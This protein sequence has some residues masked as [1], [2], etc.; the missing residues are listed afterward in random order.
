MAQN[1]DSHSIIV[2]KTNNSEKKSRRSQEFLSTLE[3]AST[4]LLNP[5]SKNKRTS[6]HKETILISFDEE[7]NIEQL[8]AELKASGLFDIVEPNFIGHGES[9]I[10]NDP[11]FS[12]RQ[13]YHVNNGSFNDVNGH[14]AKV[15]ADMDTDLAWDITTGSDQVVL[16]VFDSGLRLDHKEFEGR[17]WVNKGEIP[18]NG[19]DD[20]NNGYVDDINGWDFVNNDNDPTDD[21]AHG[22]N[23]TGIAASTGN[24]GFGMAGMDWNCKIMTLKVLDA[25]NSGRYSDWIES[26]YYAADN[27]LHIGNMSLSGSSFSQSFQDAVDYA[28]NAGALIVVAMG[29]NDYANVRYPAGFENSMAIGATNPDDLRVTKATSSWGSN[30][31][32]HIDCVAPGN[33]VYSTRYNSATSFTWWMGGTSQATPQVA[34]LACLMKGLDLSLTPDEIRNLI[35]STAEDQVGDPTEDIEGFD[36]YYGHGRINAYN[37]LLELLPKDNYNLALNSIDFTNELCGLQGSPKVRVTNKGIEDLT[38]IKL[39]ILLDDIYLSSKTF[40]VNLSSNTSE[41]LD[42]GVI[43]F[44][45]GEVELKVTV[46][47]LNSNEDEDPSDDELIQSINVIDRTPYEFFIDLESMNNAL[48]F[49][50][51]TPF[52]TIESAEINYSETAEERIYNMCLA[53]DCYE[54]SVNNPFGDGCEIEEWKSAVDYC[55][56]DQVSLNGK[57]YEAKWCGIGNDPS[58]AEEWGQWLNLGAC[59]SAI[60]TDVFGLRS[61]SELVFE[62]SV[63]EFSAPFNEEYCLGSITSIEEI[64][65]DSPQTAFIVSTQD[66]LDLPEEV[67][68]GYIYS[69]EGKLIKK[70]KGNYISFTE[71]R[72]GLYLLNT[73]GVMRKILVQ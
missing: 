18:G 25:D 70:V 15:G 36:N 20:D 5:G 64:K 4:R 57:L 29:N 52:K 46:N 16:G 1:Y 50:F 13:Y 71:M 37:A 47:T 27:G 12:S 8:I 6:E 66:V 59:E 22:T 38:E 41:V 54:I 56:G 73:N 14:P 31:G 9:T 30:Y 62:T 72:P 11:I 49:S 63:T 23:V 65:N 48:T 55:G 40:P 3:G 19:I 67:D 28:Y 43:N 26:L 60:D 21:H 2:Q 7:Q 33:R 39:D 51:T 34:G 61:T 42:L 10:P 53:D 45:E 17:L 35:N 44:S 58:T 24:N 32:S 68:F 69:I